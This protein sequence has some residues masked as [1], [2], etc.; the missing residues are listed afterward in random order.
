MATA[1]VFASMGHADN[2]QSVFGEVD[3]QNLG[4]SRTRSA[5]H[6]PTCGEHTAALTPSLDA[7]SRLIADVFADFR[8]PAL[9]L[10]YQ[11]AAEKQ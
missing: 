4:A 8:K 7:R 5:I 3:P 6:S 10:E 2:E 1:E 11:G 9:L